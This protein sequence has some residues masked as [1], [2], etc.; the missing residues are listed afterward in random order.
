MG[1]A[2][3]G[4]GI[5]P[6]SLAELAATLPLL[7]PISEGTARADELC[8]SFGLAQARGPL[9][10]LHPGSGS[11]AKCWPPSSF[12]A[13]AAALHRMGATPL[14]IAGPA[15]AVAVAAATRALP[16]DTPAPPVAGD[17]ALGTLAALLVRCA[18]FVG[19]D[20]GVSHLAAMLGVPA[21]ALFG[22]TNPAVWAPLG[23][24]VRVLRS[25][26]SAIAELPVAEVCGAVEAWLR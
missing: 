13:L 26:S 19:N 23:P 18:A 3:A 17:L 15:D 22:P 10:A 9:V 5:A 4:L 11:V 25:P 16:A 1:H 12:A 7:R 24:H 8:A 6:P 2:L 21:L 20:S 14:L